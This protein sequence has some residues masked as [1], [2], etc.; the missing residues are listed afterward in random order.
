MKGRL[1]V[2]SS[3]KRKAIHELIRDVKQGKID[4]ILFWRIDRWSRNPDF[5][6]AQDILDEHGVRWISTS[7]PGINMETRDGRLRA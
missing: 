7:E 1:P 2:R 4:V 5:Y 3:K 6:K